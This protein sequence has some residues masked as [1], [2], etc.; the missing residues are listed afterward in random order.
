MSNI[1]MAYPGERPVIDFGFVQNVEPGVILRFQQTNLYVDGFD[2]RNSRI[3]GFQVLVGQY[4]VIRRMRMRDHNLIRAN[5]DGTN[6]SFIMCVT[7][8][9]AYGDYLAIQDNEFSNAPSDMAMKIYAQRKLL[10]EG[11]NLHDLFFGTELKAD[12]PQF[13]YRGNRHFNIPGRS[14]GGNMHDSPT[15]GEILFNLVNTPGSEAA[16]DVNQDGMAGRIDIYRN[17]FIGRVRVRN[18]DL[19][20]GPFRFQNNVIVSSDTGTSLLSRIYLESVSDLLR[21]TQLNDLT[22]APS[23]GIVD[24]TGNLTANFSQYVGSRG[25]QI[26]VVPRPP[27]GVTVQ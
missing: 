5:L 25:H 21:I 26:G 3:I 18:T 10:I 4:G 16:L 9:G 6:A 15:T 8:G 22:G 19:L 1:W 23:A 27:T 14:I 11:N 13:T 20:D 7:G 2:T 24:A 12:M 17:T